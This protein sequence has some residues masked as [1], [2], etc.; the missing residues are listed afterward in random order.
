MQEFYYF[1][2]EVLRDNDLEEVRKK[3]LTLACSF[4]GAM[5]NILESYGEDNVVKINLLTTALVDGID[6]NCIEVD[7]ALDTFKEY[8]KD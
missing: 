4:T 5:E 8:A 1:D 3:G 6:C 2:I 7:E